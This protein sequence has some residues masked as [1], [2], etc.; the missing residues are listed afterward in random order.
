MTLNSLTMG[1]E[2]SRPTLQ[3]GPTLSNISNKL[4]SYNWIPSYQVLKTPIS[5]KVNTSSPL[6]QDTPLVEYFDLRRNM[7]Q[8]SQE[9]TDYCQVAKAVAVLIN[10]CLLQSKSLH[11]FP[12]SYHYLL[13]LLKNVA[14]TSQLHSFGHLSEIIRNFGICSHDDFLNYQERPSD[15][16]F[17]LAR[18]FRH[19]KFMTVP[20]VL[21]NIKSL[22]ANETPLL[23][24]MP[25]Y[26]NFLKTETDPRLTLT[27]NDDILLGGFC[28]LI[29]GYQET[30]CHFIVMT[31][32]GKRW[33]DRGYIFIPYQQIIDSGAEIVKI[34]FISELI[35][36]DLEKSN[37][38]S[39]TNY[40]ARPM[41]QES[42]E[43]Q[44]SHQEV[45]SFKTM[46]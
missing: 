29:V 17:R 26:S 23:L 33:G 16:T 32:K 27:N 11:T 34:D 2:Q 19:I 37:Q 15:E 39:P 25:V 46:F 41:N 36:L 8:M 20:V 12:P 18:P 35:K 28:G 3:E 21:D 42:N 40:H 10:Y 45:T 7:P 38:L 9:N 6:D 44:T 22:L 1:S 30:D 43:Y 5:S 31:T 24:G 14:G 4:S 13:Y